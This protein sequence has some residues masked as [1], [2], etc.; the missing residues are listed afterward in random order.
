MRSRLM[1]SSCK[2]SAAS[3]SYMSRII[4]FLCRNPQEKISASCAQ[5][6]QTTLAR[7]TNQV[8]T[9]EWSLR[10]RRD[11]VASRKEALLRRV[12]HVRDAQ[13]LYEVALAGGVGGIAQVTGELEGLVDRMIHQAVPSSC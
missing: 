11:E 12:E 3:P 1:S 5:L 8:E 13:R 10:Q 9:I 7:L 2:H 6:K 4:F